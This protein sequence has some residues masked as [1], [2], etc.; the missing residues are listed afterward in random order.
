MSRSG[1]H[2]PFVTLGSIRRAPPPSLSPP[3]SPI[4]SP[5][6]AHYHHHH[7]PT[8]PRPE[9]EFTLRLRAIGVSGRVVGTATSGKQRLLRVLMKQREDAEGPY[10]R[11]FDKENKRLKL[12]IR[13]VDSLT[14]VCFSSRFY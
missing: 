5:K 3:V 14:Y 13:D 8:R 1:S 11:S 7:I 2:E 6:N 12:N 4:G 10:E 9:A